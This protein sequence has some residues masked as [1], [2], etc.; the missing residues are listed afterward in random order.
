M[1][2]EELHQAVAL[3]ERL[4]H[5]FILTVDPEG[6]PH[7]AAA[8]NL[9]LAPDGR[10]RV[11]GWFCPGTVNNLL[12]GDRISLVVWDQAADSGYQL[13]GRAGKPREVAVLDGYLPEENAS[14]PIPQINREV[15]IRVVK[16]LAFSHGPHYDVEMD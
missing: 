1:K 11:S 12:A 6:M 9:T 4:R 8:D 2:Q 16:I 14:P 3:A 13:L 7:L 15:A 5:V 10:V